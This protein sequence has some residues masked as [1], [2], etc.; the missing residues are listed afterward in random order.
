MATKLTLKLNKRIIDRA[1]KYARAKRTSLS[2]LVEDYFKSLPEEKPSSKTNSE[3]ELSP[4][5]QELSGVI[6]L[7]ED[8]DPKAE[9]TKYLIGKYT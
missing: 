7:P 1:K 8:F 6:E 4:I 5:V 3:I 9:Y 2:L